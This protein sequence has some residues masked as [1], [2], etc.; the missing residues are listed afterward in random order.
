[1]QKSLQNK[2]IRRLC[3]AAGAV[4]FALVL[5]NLGSAGFSS[6]PIEDTAQALPAGLSAQ[7]TRFV[8]EL[9]PQIRQENI[10]ISLE[11]AKLLYL[12]DR[13]SA[14]NKLDPRQI[15]WI[16]ALGQK[17]KVDFGPGEH[18]AHKQALLRR[19]D[20]IPV[21][22]ALAQAANESAWGTSRF[23]REGNNLFGQW[24]FEEGCGLVP[25]QRGEGQNHEVKKFSS[26]AE[27]VRAYF[28]NLNTNTAYMDFRKERHLARGENRPLEGMRLAKGLRNYSAL[29]NVYVQSLVK[30][31]N[32][33]GFAAL[34]TAPAAAPAL[35]L[36]YNKNG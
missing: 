14:E 25:A 27:S 10:K 1:M 26:T 7:K 20:I 22:L 18:T 6:R 30:I 3:L 21:S 24:C 19:V 15:A 2:N 5:L 11:R 4:C 17:Y 13:E 12:L 28:Y 36:A 31:M 35:A 9:I 16:Q 32:D 23:A 8:A 33:S 29:G 34:D